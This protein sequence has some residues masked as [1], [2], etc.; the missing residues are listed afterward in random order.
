MVVG[1][2]QV[3]EEIPAVRDTHLRGP[4]DLGEPL[5]DGLGDDHVIRDHAEAPAEPRPAGRP[6]ADRQ[7]H[8]VG[9]D[10]AVFGAHH[11]R[12]RSIETGHRS[13][14]EDPNTTLERDA[15]QA[16]GET[17]GLHDRAVV[18]ESSAGN[19]RGVSDLASLLHRERSHPVAEA[20]CLQERRGPFATGALLPRPGS[21]PQD[22]LVME[23][24][25]DAVLGEPCS[26][27][28]DRVR[29][30]VGIAQ[31]FERPRRART[32]P[33]RP[34]MTR[35]RS[36]RC[37]RWRRRHRCPAPA[38]RCASWVRGPKAR[39]PSRA[40]ANPPPTMQTSAATCDSRGG[41][42]SPGSAPRASWSQKLRAAPGSGIVRR[43]LTR[44][45][46][47]GSPAR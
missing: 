27:L 35:R 44:G 4:A 13:A 38:A 34:T 25:V 14:F 37:A 2:P 7:H 32:A 24:G 15:T 3:E 10:R 22:P 41:H 18:D 8:L 1:G 23:P 26:G 11:R 12:P 46:V 47:A 29:H 16:T 45:A 39:W 43:V 33:R 42:G 40:R 21:D 9:L 31:P 30:R 20:T 28:T 19:P 6:G 36:R 17:G 5:R